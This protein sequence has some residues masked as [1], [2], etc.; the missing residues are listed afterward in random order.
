MVAQID[1]SNQ[2]IQVWSAF[3]RMLEHMF[4]PMHPIA[5]LKESDNIISFFPSAMVF[6]VWA[7]RCHC[8]GCY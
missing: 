4:N 7:E 5:T 8:N 1:E 3:N 2:D 6:V